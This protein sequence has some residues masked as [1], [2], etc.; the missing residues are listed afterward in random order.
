MINWRQ[1]WTDVSVISLLY[2]VVVY[3]LFRLRRRQQN[4]DVDAERQHQN[5]VAVQSED[6]IGP[7]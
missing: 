2:Y 7:S 3:I 1:Y 5:D 6:V 4:Y